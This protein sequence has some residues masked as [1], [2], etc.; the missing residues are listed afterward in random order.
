M[1]KLLATFLALTMLLSTAACS[2]GG[3]PSSSAG[4]DE[5]SSQ[6]VETRDINGLTLP[7]SAEKQEISVLMVYDSQIVEDPNEIA[8]VKAMEEATNVHVNWMTYSQAEMP[9]KFQQMLATGEYFDIMFPGGVEAYSGGYVQGVEDGVLIDMDE[10]IQKYM[11]NYLAL[12]ESNEDAKKQ[13]TSDDGIMHSVRVIKGTDQG[14]QGPGAILG[15]A[16]RADIL[17][18]LGAD[19]PETVEDLHQLL[20]QCR[21]Q[22]MTAPMTLQADGGTTLSLAWG[23]NTDWSTNFWQYDYETDTVYFAPFAEGWDEWHDTMRDW[24]AEGLIDKNFT[25]GSPMLTSDYSIFENNQTLFIDTWFSHVMGNE[26]YKQGFISNEGVDIQAIAGIVL[27][28]GDEPVKCSWDA[29]LGQEIFVTTLAEDKIDVVSKW[30]DYQYTEEGIDYRYYGIEGESYTIDQNGNKTFTDAILNN[31]DGLSISDSLAPFAMRTYCGF[32]SQT[33]ENAVSIAAA[34]D[35][36]V[37]QIESV[38]I[39]ASPKITVHMPEVVLNT[40]ENE[41]V[42]TYMTDILTL[43]QERMAKYILGT[44]TTSHD[45]FREKLKEYHIEEVTQCYQDACDRFNAR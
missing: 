39:W 7:I 43:L 41:L 19:V 11:P 25:A 35:G 30:L 2:N 20:I 34:G 12:L 21:D 40:E 16:Y 6:S 17:K 3:E 29:C 8:G 10:N 33:A 4:G 24:Y 28:S 1:K 37:S 13:A 22:G 5:E 26:L 44:D 27:N 38:E 14:V 32:Q 9:E 31:P 23:V 18:E 45:E 15:P 42:N 36:A